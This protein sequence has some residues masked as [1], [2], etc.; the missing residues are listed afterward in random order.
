MWQ[1]AWVAALLGTGMGSILFGMAAI[2]TRGLAV[3]IG[4]HAAWNLG[5]WALGDKQYPGLWKI[6]VDESSRSSAQMAG[7][8]GYFCV[9]GLATL[10]FWLLHR[11]RGTQLT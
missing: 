9:M 2:A 1:G 5:A 4:I 11:R 6:V 8:T 3:P 7:V 10:G